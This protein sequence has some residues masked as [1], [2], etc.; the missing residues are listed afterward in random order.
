MF[1]A[2]HPTTHSGDSD[3]DAETEEE[4]VSQSDLIQVCYT[5]YVIV[6]SS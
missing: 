3:T 2:G 6:M 5:D 1:V 4:N